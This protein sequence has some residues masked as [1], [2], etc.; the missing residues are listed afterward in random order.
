[1]S[2]VNLIGLTRNELRSFA[3]SINEESYRGDQIFSWIY[4][5]NEIK[6][7]R[8]TNLS[9][10][11]RSNIENS[12]FLN[13]P[14]IS[15]SV[16]SKETSSIKFLFKL[17]DG[18]SIETVFIPEQKR[19]TVCLSSQVGCAL[20]CK[21][22]AT[23]KMGILRNLTVA[24][25]MGQLLS[26]IK[27]TKQKI[28]NIVFMG[29]GEPMMNY[30]NV[31]KAADIIHDQ[32]GLNIGARKITISTVGMVKKIRQYTKEKHPYNIAFSLNA[33]NDFERSK[34]MPINKKYN[35]KS[36]LD[37][38]KDYSDKLKRPA[39]IEYV[40]ISGVNDTYEDAIRLAKIIKSLD[41]KLNVIPYN[42]IK[43][44]SFKRPTEYEINNF[45]NN[46]RSKS[47]IITVRWS[48]GKDVNAACGQLYTT[49]E[50]K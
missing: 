42:P 38:L 16:I 27:E 23:A 43:G 36:C 50:K 26:V 8:M 18:L 39:M 34:L 24:E 49:N 41:C 47:T 44:E 40:L 11:F 45:I 28:T 19:N 15:D 48:Q 1:M 9:K 17:N 7:S 29:M 32:K 31:I 6:F 3:E 21:F 10:G 22:C 14:K 13:L 2:N 5:Y 12:A 20:D 35:L 4:Q 37:A 33:T 46:I 25:I 30:N